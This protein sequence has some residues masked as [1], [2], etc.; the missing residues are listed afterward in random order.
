MGILALFYKK[1]SEEKE[2]HPNNIVGKR[3]TVTETVDN[4]AGCGQVKVNGQF[5]AARAAYDEDRFEIGETIKIVAI[6]GVR[7]V[8]VRS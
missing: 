1:S 8:C 3:C 7:L 5:W 4:N 6:E 2:F